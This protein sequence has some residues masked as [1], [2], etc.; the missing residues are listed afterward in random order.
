M[1]AAAQHH[2]ETRRPMESAFIENPPQILRTSIKARV[3]QPCR[4]SRRRN[5]VNI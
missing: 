3:C 4:R 2:A 5:L 1:V